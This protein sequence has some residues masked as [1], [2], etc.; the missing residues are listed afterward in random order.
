MAARTAARRTAERLGVRLML[1]LGACV[2]PAFLLIGVV[3]ILLGIVSST[4]AG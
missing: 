4:L 3:P 2:L 1:P